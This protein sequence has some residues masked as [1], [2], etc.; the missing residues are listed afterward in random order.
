MRICRRTRGSCRCGR[1]RAYYIEPRDGAGCDFGP[2]CAFA[3]VVGRRCGRDCAGVATS[4]GFTH[5]LLFREG[6]NGMLQSGYDPM[7]CLKWKRC[8]RWSKKHLQLVYGDA[9]LGLT[10]QGWKACARRAG[11]RTVC[12]LCPQVVIKRKIGLRNRRAVAV[13]V[14]VVSRLV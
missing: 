3:C 13:W 12:G 6:L 4:K 8:K 2:F 11:N 14:W 1:P 5:V 10:S 9:P 7:A